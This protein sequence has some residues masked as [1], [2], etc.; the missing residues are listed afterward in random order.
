MTQQLTQNDT[1][2]I[3]SSEDST[4]TYDDVFS[5]EVSFNSDWDSESEEGSHP[6]T[7]GRASS[8]NNERVHSSRKR[9]RMD[10]RETD[11]RRSRTLPEKPEGSQL[12][13]AITKI[14]FYIDQLTQ[15]R[16]AL[17]AMLPTEVSENIPPKDKK[18]IIKKPRQCAA[19][20]ENK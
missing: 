16:L 15:E 5:D 18:K 17:Q 4:I 7:S 19:K 20:T 9:S 14:G 2:S 1:I 13:F 8:S 10:R 3:S 11:L 12:Q 6:K